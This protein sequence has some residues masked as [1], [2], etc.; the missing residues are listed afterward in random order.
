M[1]ETND[2]TTDLTKDSVQPHQFDFGEA[3][4]LLKEGC[5]VT[6]LGWNGKGMY[7]WLLPEAIVKREWV[8]DNMLLD[9]MGNSDEIKCLPSIRMKTA[10][11]EV[12]TGWL[13]SQTDM[14]AT[15]WM[16]VE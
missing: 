13:A 10:T 12:L 1:N 9:A 6:R 11:G 14:F 4:R 2:L 15:D 16:I 5:K 7:L 8:R 3:L